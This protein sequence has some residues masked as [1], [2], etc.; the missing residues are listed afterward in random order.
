MKK[1]FALIYAAILSA[2]VA[3]DDDLKF[4]EDKVYDYEFNFESLWKEIDEK[5]C[6]FDYKKDSIKDWND[7]HAE[8]LPYVIN[9]KTDEEFFDV[10]A[11]MLNELKDG[12]VNLISSFDFS[13]YDFY[14]NYPDDYDYDVMKSDRYLGKNARYSGGFRYKTLRDGNVGYMYF[15]D[16]MSEFTDDQLNYILS[17]LRTLKA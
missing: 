4:D 8:Y 15:P 14:E 12:H 17:F 1:I 7:V 16:F 5:Y 2:F 3:C 11:A 13:S 6:F 10:L 9:C